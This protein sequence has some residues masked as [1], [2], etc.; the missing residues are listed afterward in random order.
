MP[1]IPQPPDVRFRAKVARFTP[2]ECW[3]WVT[4]GAYG[5]ITIDGRTV[6]AHRYSYELHNGPLAAGLVV[7]HRCDNP[8]CVNPAHLFAGTATDNVQDAIAKGRWA[9]LR[10]LD[11]YQG[12]KTH[13]TEGHPY[14]DENTYRPPG[15]P[16]SRQCAICRRK[17]SRNAARKRRAMEAAA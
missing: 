11:N 10:G 5:K 13:C 12:R 7:C 17:H 3:P 6:Y 14:T 15:R 16:T 8:P 4:S 2:D 9:A 1:P